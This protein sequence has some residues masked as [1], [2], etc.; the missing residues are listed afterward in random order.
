MYLDERKQCQRIDL[1]FD[2]VIQDYKTVRAALYRAGG[3]NAQVHGRRGYCHTCPP[4]S[5][6][7]ISAWSISICKRGLLANIPLCLGRSVNLQNGL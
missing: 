2:R 6:S 4:A 5:V 7:K 1:L 3:L